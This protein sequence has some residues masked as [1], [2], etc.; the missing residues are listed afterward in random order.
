MDNLT[1]PYTFN[2]FQGTKNKMFRSFK[3]SKGTKKY[4][5]TTFIVV[6]VTCNLYNKSLGKL[7]F[8][9]LM[10]ENYFI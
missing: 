5:K 7:G 1:S 10:K 6:H 8:L 3:A 2:F 4:N 9:Q